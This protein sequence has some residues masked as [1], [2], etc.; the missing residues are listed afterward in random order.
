MSQRKEIQYNKCCKIK[1]CGSDA[2]ITNS[3][4]C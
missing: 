3:N 2:D 4:G 1:L